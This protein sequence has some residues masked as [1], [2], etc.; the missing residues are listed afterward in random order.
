MF[1]QN[2]SALPIVLLLLACEQWFENDDL[3][4]RFYQKQYI[5]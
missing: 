2:L 3:K 5:L 1:E 4:N